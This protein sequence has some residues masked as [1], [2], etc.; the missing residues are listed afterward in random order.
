MPSSPSSEAAVSVAMLAAQLTGGAT[1]TPTPCAGGGNNRVFRV[2]TAAGPRALKLYPALA[3]DPRDRLGHE[4]TALRFLAGRTAPGRLP[5]AVAADRKAG[6]ALYEWV[7]GVPVVGHGV[8]E[9]TAVLD[10]LGELRRAGPAAADIGPAVE[11]CLAP[12]DILARIAARLEPLGRIAASEPGLAAVLTTIRDLLAEI[13]AGLQ[14]AASDRPLPAAALVLSPSDFGFHNALRRSDGSLTFLD[15]EYFGWDDPVKAAS[16]FLWHAGQRLDVAQRVAFATGVI[17][18]YGA[19][20][21]FI[22]RLTALYPLHGLHWALIVLNEFRPD[23]WER[24][25]MAGS[26][27]DWADAKRRQL[28]KAERL[29]KRVE[30]ALRIQTAPIIERIAETGDDA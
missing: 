4:F 29:V 22:P 7:D 25:R 19:S 21:G 20:P 27:D 3:D 1:P 14:D 28:A 13:R 11:P 24:R 5:Q 26:V 16:D 23:R 15:F 2:E 17:N 8:T 6:A 9:I 18:L 12:A 30:R 10:L